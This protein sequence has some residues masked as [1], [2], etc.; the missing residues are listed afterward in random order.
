MDNWAD[1]GN[2][3]WAVGLGGILGLCELL[4]R[5]R[6]E[7]LQAVS[8]WYAFFFVIV[9]SLAAGVAFFL[10]DA[11]GWMGDA[12]EGGEVRHAV[13]HIL[14]AG[15]G[16]MAFFRSSIFNVK[17]DDKEV[18]VGP[19]LIFQIL[20]QVTDRAVDRNRATARAKIVPKIM[21]KVNFD[22]SVPA[23]PVLCMALMQN[24]SKEEQVGLRS[25][26]DTIEANMGSAP[27]RLKSIMLGLIVLDFVGEEALMEAANTY[28]AAVATA[29]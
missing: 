14:T 8:N 1:F 27:D 26:V 24:L 10:I 29:P 28:N 23:F 21:A 18:P 2:L 11:L 6:D 22:G 13:I 3:V 16:A 5:Y 12:P 17:F 25:K 7:P 4:G 19:G 15:F 20:I 9:N